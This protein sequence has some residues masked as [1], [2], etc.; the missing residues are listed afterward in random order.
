MLLLYY[1]YLI[2][3]LPHRCYQPHEEGLIRALTCRLEARSFPQY[4]SGFN[5][6]YHLRTPNDAGYLQTSCEAERFHKIIP[7]SHTTKRNKLRF[8]LAHFRHLPYQ[9]Q[10]CRIHLLC[11]RRGHISRTVNGESWLFPI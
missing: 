7:R 2:C 3:S 1:Y 11:S 5:Q 4:M 6:C 9:I 8:C 10:M